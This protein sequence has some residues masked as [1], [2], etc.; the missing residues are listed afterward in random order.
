[1]RN[2]IF[3]F[4]YLFSCQA[5]H[6]K[7]PWFKTLCQ[8][9]EENLPFSFKNKNNNKNKKLNKNI[10][11]KSPFFYQGPICELI[12]NFKFHKDLAAG[13]FLSQFLI[14]YLNKNLLELPDLI[15]SVPLHIKKLR[16]RG[17][18]QSILIAKWL[19][20]N[21]QIPVNNKMIRR[22]KFTQAQINLSRKERLKN[23]KNAFELIN[24]DQFKKL[25]LKHVAV[26]DDVVT[27]GATVH[28]ISKILK[29]AGVEKVEVWCLARAVLEG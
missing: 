11:V 17:F 16:A 28:E 4:L 29:R 1:M 20:K 8:D 6:S 7:A 10:E 18:N 5:C 13:K 23:L 2:S 9:C 12:Q 27:T 19:G 15:I 3:S 22:H 14:K 25:G 24:P 26:V 21:L